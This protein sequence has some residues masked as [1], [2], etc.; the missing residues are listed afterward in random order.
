MSRRKFLVGDRVR[1]KYLEELSP[2]VKQS[3]SNQF[4]KMFGG[5]KGKII[6]YEGSGYYEFGIR[7][8]MKVNV[9][10]VEV[11]KQGLPEIIQVAE[12]S[13]RSLEYLPEELFSL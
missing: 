13:L 12:V 11:K 9:C 10:L 6:G 2:E 4:F 5:L 1:V 7:R 8:N 3:L